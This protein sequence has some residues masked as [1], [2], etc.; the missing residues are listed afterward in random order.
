M[1]RKIFPPKL[2]V[3][4][5]AFS[6]LCNPGHSAFLAEVRDAYELPARVPIGSRGDIDPS[7]RLE[8]GIRDFRKRAHAEC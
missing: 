1:G 3:K 2:A 5:S 8:A 7:A 4:H 6:Y